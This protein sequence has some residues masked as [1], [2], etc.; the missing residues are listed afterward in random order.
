MNAHVLGFDNFLADW[1]SDTLFRLL[2]G[3]GFAT[4]QLYT[5]RDEVLLDA[6]RAR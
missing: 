4:R 6:L 3:G 1:I 5:D 2:T